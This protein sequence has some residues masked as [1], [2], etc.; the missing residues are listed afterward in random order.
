MKEA[1]GEPGEQKEMFQE[2]TVNC[3][4]GYWQ[5]KSGEALL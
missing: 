3:I 4:T 2:G 5:F 1:R